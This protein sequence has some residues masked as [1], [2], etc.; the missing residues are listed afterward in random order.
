M[1]EKQTVRQD[2]VMAALNAATSGGAT[3]SRSG[4]DGGVQGSSSLIKLNR[5]N[6]AS[7]YIPFDNLEVGVPYKIHRFGTYNDDRYSTKKKKHQVRLT[8]FIE[9]GYLILP[10]R[11]DSMVAE[12]ESIDAEK[13]YIIF[14]GRNENNRFRNIEFIE[15]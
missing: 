15:K 8:A 4:V 6:K 11:F 5:C 3:S 13:M 2:G 1:A 10:E 12:V 9:N 14:N 7:S